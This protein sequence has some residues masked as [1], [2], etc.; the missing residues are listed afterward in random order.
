MHTKKY[1]K[2][3]FYSIN[4]FLF[5]VLFNKSIKNL[6]TVT[7]ALK[8]KTHEITVYQQN[9]FTS[10]RFFFTVNLTNAECLTATQLVLIYQNSQ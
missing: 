9:V 2:I 7:K 10:Q 3:V 6:I 5:N 1:I 8:I 4:F